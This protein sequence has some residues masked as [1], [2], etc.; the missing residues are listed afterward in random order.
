MRYWFTYPRTHAGEPAALL[1]KD[2]LIRVAQAAEASGFSGIGFTDHPAPSR[3]WLYSKIGHDAL[4]P[5]VALAVVAAATEHIQLIPNILILPYRNPFV[6]AKAAATLDVLSSSRFVLAVALGYMQTEYRALGVEFERRGAIFD[7]SLAV[8]RRVLSEDE[9][10][11][12]AEGYAADSI[13]VFPKP[14][15]R[16]PIW[17]GG[18]SAASRRRVAAHGD[19]WNPFSAPTTEAATMTRTTRIGGLDDL[20]PLLEHLW[21]EVEAAGRDRSAIDVVF[22][23]SLPGAL[24]RHFDPASHL[25]AVERMKGMGITWASTIFG[26]ASVD[27]LIEGI[28]RYGSEVIAQSR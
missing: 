1:T 7:E 11:F 15:R 18:N 21:R 10:S 13:A 3:E 19:G 28:E 2:A 14:T 8:V 6:V 12:E 27:A 25:A 5:F 22:T 4:D 20:A 26:T 9:F 24:D 16:L 23:N 17:I